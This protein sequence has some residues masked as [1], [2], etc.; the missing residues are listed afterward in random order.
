MFKFKNSYKLL[1]VFLSMIALAINSSNVINS[2]KDAMTLCFTTVIPSLFPFMVLS[3]MFVGNLGEGSLKF[4]QKGAKSIF[5]ISHYGCAAFICGILCGYPVGAKCVGNLY[6]EGKISLSEAESLVAYSNNSG[7]L[8]IIGAVGVGMFSSVKIGVILYLMHILTALI[9]A[10]LLK[11]YTY[12]KVY[13]SKSNY[14]KKEL[15]QCIC[16]S[17]LSI[18]NV[19]GFILFFAFVNELIVPL[20]KLMPS[21]IKILLTSFLEITNGA[22]TISEC[23]F[24]KE[25]KIALCAMALGWSGLSVHLQVKSILSP[26]GIS[27]K[28]Y[29]ICRVFISFVS[30]ILTFLIVNNTDNIALFALQNSKVIF[31]ILV[32]SFIP[33]YLSC[34]KHKTKETI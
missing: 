31:L 29:Y 1:I 16:E 12:S 21:L 23:G 11:P 6:K 28:K 33:L 22:K 7:P 10:L 9:C 4:L 5:G 25:I 20:V 2:L 26:L 13:I 24:S 8:F 14:R 34:K 27:L 30:C 19:C 32:L 3:N 17:T 15:A 18:L